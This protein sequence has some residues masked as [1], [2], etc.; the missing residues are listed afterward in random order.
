MKQGPIWPVVAGVSGS[1]IITGG[2]TVAT[3]GFTLTIPA[4]G[5]AALLGTAQTFTADQTF[6]GGSNAIKV[7][8]PTTAD[9]LADVIIGTSATTQKG[10]VVQGSPSQSANAFEI[11][12]STGYG[13]LTA[14]VGGTVIG[15]GYS[16]FTAGY[17]VGTDARINRKAAAVLEVTNGSIGAAI[18]GL[19]GGGSTVASNT[20]M[21]APT[22]R[23]FHVSGTTAITSI[24]ST[25]FAAGTVI[26]L[27]FDDALTFTDGNN[28][29]LAGNFST[30]ADDTITLAY[31]GTNWYEVCRSVN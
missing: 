23:V 7:G 1:G 31:D 27:I 13:Y 28:L 12:D 9:V 29:K 8:T 14:T 3:G 21:P 24:T 16:Q 6:T 26:T 15:V 10:L 25:A 30:S 19:I 4:T 17:I 11:Q 5:T 20:A 18:S 22:G 2:G